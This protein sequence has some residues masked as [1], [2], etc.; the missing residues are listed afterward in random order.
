MQTNHPLVR[1][2][3]VCHEKRCLASTMATHWLSEPAGALCK[4]NVDT[5][6]HTRASK[7]PVV[8]FLDL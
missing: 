7:P 4:Q 8:Y 5:H 2:S 1:Q 6:T 3:L